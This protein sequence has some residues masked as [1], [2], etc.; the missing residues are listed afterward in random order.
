MV[1]WHWVGLDSTME[2]IYLKTKK[3]DKTNLLSFYVIL[4]NYNPLII[5]TVEQ[6]VNTNLYISTITGYRRDKRRNST[7]LFFTINFLSVSLT[8][9]YRS[10]DNIFWIT[11]VIFTSY[12][13]PPA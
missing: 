11:L 5:F 2:L 8:L 13:A 4:F 1:K 12:P 10:I 9:S 7:V 3:V 6:P